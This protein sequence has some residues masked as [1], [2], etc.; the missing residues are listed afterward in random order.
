MGASDIMENRPV[1]INLHL[2]PQF[3]ELPF[4]CGVCVQRGSEK[5]RKSVSKL[6]LHLRAR[7]FNSVETISLKPVSHEIASK[8]ETLEPRAKCETIKNQSYSMPT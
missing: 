3:L 5:S 1:G 4:Q 6:Q 7:F 8:P 2:Y